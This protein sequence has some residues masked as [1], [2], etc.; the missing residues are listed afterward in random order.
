MTKGRSKNRRSINRFLEWRQHLFGNLLDLYE[1][2]W[3]NEINSRTF[4]F[5][6]PEEERTTPLS[7]YREG[8]ER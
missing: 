1:I 6:G 8:R 5:I 2:Q 4:V 3:Y 7:T